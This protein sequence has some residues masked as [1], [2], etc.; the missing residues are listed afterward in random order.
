MNLMEIKQLSNDVYLFNDKKLEY[1]NDNSGEE[2]SEVR[3]KKI[4]IKKS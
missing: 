3:N 2:I 4:S 1:Y